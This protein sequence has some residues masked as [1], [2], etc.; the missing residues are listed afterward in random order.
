MPV[1]STELF[2]LIVV[3]IVVLGPSKLPE[4]SAKLARLVMQ[5]RR[6]AN[7]ARGQLREQMG[8]D[9]DDLDWRQYDPRQYD[10][11][12]IVRE[13]LVE[14]LE[15]AFSLD[16]K[17]SRRGSST[18]DEL[19]PG[20]EPGGAPGDGAEGADRADRAAHAPQLAGEPGVPTPWDPEAT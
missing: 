9:F 2:V 16:D 14:P 3:A 18:P 4:Y 6:M 19:P 13:A 17:P 1:H 10:P 12:R 15:D 5:V 8:P 20:T 7:D 11:R